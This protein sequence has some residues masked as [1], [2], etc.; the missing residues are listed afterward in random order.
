MR[1]RCPCYPAEDVLNIRSV[2]EVSLAPGTDRKHIKA[3]E[4][5][6]SYCGSFTYDTGIALEGDD[7]IIG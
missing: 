5:V 1:D 3:V 6:V 4:E 7:G 2:V